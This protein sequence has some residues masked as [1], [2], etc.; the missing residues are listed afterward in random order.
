MSAVSLGKRFLVAAILIPAVLYGIYQQHVLIWFLAVLSFAGM[1][2]FILFRNSMLNELK[3][4]L[5][6]PTQSNKK[7]DQQDKKMHNE[8]HFPPSMDNYSFQIIFRCTLSAF[9][10]L[11]V[12]F[13]ANDENGRL[14]VFAAWLIGCLSIFSVGTM[15]GYLPAD[16]DKRSADEQLH[17]TDFI[18][19]CMDLFGLLYTGGCLS[20][21]VMLLKR[22]QFLLVLT[23]TANWLS[24]AFA[25]LF[26]KTFG[27]FKILGALHKKLSPNKTREGGV[28]AVLGSMLVCYILRL[29]CFKASNLH[30]YLSIPPLYDMLIY[31]FAIGILSILGDLVESFM[32]RVGRIKDSGQFFSSHGGVLDRLDGLLFTFPIVFMGAILWDH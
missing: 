2:E 1:R 3:I 31:G 30:Q 22:N 12:F 17:V 6:P 5:A 15:L 18:S 4:D 9:V 14:Q 19:M 20:I 23:L 21:A 25:L 11:L 13:C 26:G 24:D 7:S 29:I 32:K 10:P 27:K 28:G 8:H 16:G